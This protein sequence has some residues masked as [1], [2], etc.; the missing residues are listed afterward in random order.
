M[1]YFPIINGGAGVGKSVI[2][3]KF[4]SQ[5]KGQ[6]LVGAFT[7]KVAFDNYGDTLHSLFKLPCKGKLMDMNPNDEKEFYLLFKNIKFLIIDEYSMIPS[8]FQ[9]QISKRLKQIYKNVDQ[10]YPGIRIIL[11][12][13]IGQLTPVKAQPLF[14]TPKTMEEK[15]GKKLF[16]NNFKYSLFVEENVRVD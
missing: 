4:I 12:G 2:L 16:M 15:E 9:L 1:K 10:D 3:K 14:R 6:V 8:S 5:F 11:T 7:A 13:D